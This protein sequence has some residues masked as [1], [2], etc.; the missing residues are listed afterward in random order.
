M[1]RKTITMWENVV[2]LIFLFWMRLVVLESAEVLMNPEITITLFSPLI[3]YTVA[4][5]ATTIIAVILIYRRF[6]RD[7][8]NRPLRGE[9]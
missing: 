3:F 8:F 7:A 9:T 5:V 2:G 6:G 1:E 4:G